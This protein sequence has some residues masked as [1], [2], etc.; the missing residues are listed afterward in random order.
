MGNW[1]INL[2]DRTMGSCNGPNNFSKRSLRFEKTTMFHMAVS[3]D[4]KNIYFILFI[5]EDLFHILHV[6]LVLSSRFINQLPIY[7][8]L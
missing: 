7:A 2:L 5:L 4:I 6:P 1:L 8:C 3:A